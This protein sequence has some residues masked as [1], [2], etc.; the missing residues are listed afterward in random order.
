[1]V[2]FYSLFDINYAAISLQLQDAIDF[3]II[4]LSGYRKLVEIGTS[5]NSENGIGKIS[6][7]T[8]TI[9]A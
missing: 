5:A 8:S 4:L 1:M 9:A 6:H 3:G 2:H 7:K